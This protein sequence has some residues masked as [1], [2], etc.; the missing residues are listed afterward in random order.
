MEKKGD[1]VT[2][3]AGGFNLVENTSRFSKDFVKN[4]NEDSVM[5]VV[6]KNIFLKLMLN[7]F[8]RT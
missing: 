5:K 3:P 2:L 1:F 4:Y 6:T 8:K 7:I